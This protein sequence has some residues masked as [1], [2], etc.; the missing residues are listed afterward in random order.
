MVYL[1]NLNTGRL[2]DVTSMLGVQLIGADDTTRITDSGQ[3]TVTGFGGSSD[4][5]SI[6]SNFLVTLD[7]KELPPRESDLAIAITGLPATKV[8]GDIVTATFT[9]TNYG[10]DLANNIELL[11]RIGPGLTPLGTTGPRTGS[12][13]G[14]RR[15]FTV[16]SLPNGSSVTFNIK[17]RATR[18]GRTAL[19][20]AVFASHDTNLANNTATASITV[21]PRLNSATRARVRPPNHSAARAGS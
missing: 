15:P 13:T 16:S 3:F 10:P 12:A 4:A 6:D 20:G 7:P 5:N 18:V 14:A 2:I 1:D 8:R 21:A 17:L 19:G 11:E 9:I